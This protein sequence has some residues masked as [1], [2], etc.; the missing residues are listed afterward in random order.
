MP[1]HQFDFND[2]PPIGLQNQVVGPKSEGAPE[3]QP[4][5]T[6]QVGH[7]DLSKRTNIHYE[8]LN[9]NIAEDVREILPRG[10]HTMDRGLKNYFSGIRIPTTAG[11]QFMGV[12]VAGGDKSLLI[13]QQDLRRGRVQLPVLSINRGS[14]N[15]NPQKFSPPYY[16]MTGRGGTG[17]FT[18]KTGSRRR[19]TF[20]PVPYL[21]DYT[22]IIWAEHKDEAE[23]ASY[24]ICTRFNPLAEFKVED[25][26]LR[27]NV[28][29]KQNSWRDAS[30]KDVD[31]DTRANVRYE[32]DITMEGWLP[33]PERV[34]PTILGRVTTLKEDTGEFL[35]NVSGIDVF[36]L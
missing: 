25:E 17:S 28:I 6:P 33:L 29:M 26:F 24:Q 36:P 15:Y 5:L 21:I 16:T 27:G 14:A 9:V 10:F 3:P 20:R 18:D 11:T 31:P 2:A 12:R 34:G 19:Q 13:W 32:V 22:L 35:Q 1:I 8:N 23:F 7:P 4:L 30:D